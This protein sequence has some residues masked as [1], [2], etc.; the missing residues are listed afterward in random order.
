MDRCVHAANVSH[1]LVNRQLPKERLSL[2]RLGFISASD[3]QEADLAGGATLTTL[4]FQ[5]VSHRF[6]DFQAVDALSLEMAE[7]EIVCL[8]GPSGCG[9][10]TSLRLAAGLE[11]L[12]EGRI[13]ICL[14]YTSPSPRDLSTSR[15][16]SSA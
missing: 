4:S 10:T 9:K 8:L 16:P 14:L 3:Y 6:G 2:S 15:M 1:R 5:N 11:T 7:G 13:R 12:Q